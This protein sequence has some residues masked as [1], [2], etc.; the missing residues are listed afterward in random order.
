L[1]YDLFAGLPGT[2]LL[3][4]MGLLFVLALI[5][6]LVVYGPFMRK[7]PFGA[8][9]SERSARTRWL[10][11]HNLLGIAA[12]LWLLVVGAT[13]VINA[14][15][16]PIFAHWQ[17]TEL[18]GMIEPYLDRA[19]LAEFGSVDRALATVGDEM[20]DMELGFIAFPGND[21]SG[22]HHY[23][24]YMRGATPL[25]S[26]LLRPVLIDARSGAMVDTREMPWYVSALL[27]SQPLH[28]GDYGGL[29]L[30]ILWALLTSVAIVVLGSGLYLW[31]KK[32]NISLDARLAALQSGWGGDRRNLAGRI[33][34]T[35]RSS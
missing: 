30:K 3:G 32:R 26:K 28:F 10:D 24:A 20:P 1:H 33:Q 5:S 12:F 31:L 27:L 6:G 13:G 22:P 4:A 14:L 35:G 9:R 16:I 29:P 21:F 11:L 34:P 18:A 17:D 15:A 8:I 23:V 25:T 7:L 19:P 2:L